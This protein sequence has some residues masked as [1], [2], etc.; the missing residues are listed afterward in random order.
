M[1][2][3]SGPILG[4]SFFNKEVGQALQLLDGRC[5]FF[6]AL[7]SKADTPD[8]RSEAGRFSG[9]LVLHQFA[10]KAG[11]FFYQHVSRVLDKIWTPLRDSRVS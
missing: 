1:V 7:R 2:E 5:F 10:S 3:L 9:V 4:E 11:A 6:S 8:S